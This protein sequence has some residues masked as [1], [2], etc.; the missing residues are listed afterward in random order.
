MGFRAGTKIVWTFLLLAMN[1][2]ISW[3]AYPQQPPCSAPSVLAEVYGP[4]GEP[5]LGLQANNFRAKFR[6][7]TLHILK[8]TPWSGPARV[9]LLFDLSGSATAEP[10]LTPI[11]KSIG[12]DIVRQ[13]PTGMSLAMAVF[14]SRAE[15][16]APF[17]AGTATMETKIGKLDALAKRVPKNGRRTALYDAVKFAVG[18]FGDSRLGDAICIISDGG[19]NASKIS[20]RESERALLANGVR[21]FA[22]VL[23]ESRPPRNRTPDQEEGPINLNNL[24]EKSG[25]VR[26]VL[27][28]STPFELGLSP[29]HWSE[30]VLH[31]PQ[32]FDQVIMQGYNLEIAL[33][34]AFRKPEHWKLEVVDPK[35]KMDH[36]HFVAYPWLAPCEMKP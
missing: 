22:V 35:G 8:V 32:E 18:M 12:L 7:K 4:Q 13:A 1:F 23:P 26:Y 21:L 11:E 28:G 33:P 2:A 24:A 19:N 10:N 5:A 34:S 20:R 31:V 6:G 14:A 15:V 30:S 17:S 3:A 9:V 36:Q 16:V 27:R 29:S 25:G